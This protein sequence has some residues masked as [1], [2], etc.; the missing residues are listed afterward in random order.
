MLPPS[1]KQTNK[2]PPV[3]IRRKKIER[4]QRRSNSVVIEANTLLSGEDEVH[5]SMYELNVDGWSM[6]ALESGIS[7][8]DDRTRSELC[9]DEQINSLLVVESTVHV[10]L[11][12]VKLTF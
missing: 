12:G 6:D 9:L 2:Q 3:I 11:G 4:S 1:D 10:T 7:S 8:N 5:R